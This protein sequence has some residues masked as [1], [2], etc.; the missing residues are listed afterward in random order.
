MA[1]ILQLV[2]KVEHSLREC[3]FQPIFA[4]LDSGTALAER[5]LYY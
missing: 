4:K 1:I 3:G 5:V 2:P